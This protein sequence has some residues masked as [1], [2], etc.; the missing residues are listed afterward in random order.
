[1]DYRKIFMVTDRLP[2]RIPAS[3]LPM[4]VT[5]VSG[6]TGLNTFAFLRRRYGDQ[7]L[8]QRP[9]VTEKL[10]GPGILA[11]DLNDPI[12]I[13]SIIREHGI[14]SILSTGGS[15][16]LKGCELDHE[17][18]RRVNVSTVQA[19][20]DASLDS[21]TWLVHLSI[22]LVFGGDRG[23][24]HKEADVI[25]PATMYGKTM[26]MAEGVIQAGKPD[27]CIGRISL[28]MG[29]S[30]NQHA[31]AVDWIGSRFIKGRPATLYYD[32]FRTPTYVE[33]LAEVC[34]DL[35]A[36]D[37]SGLW[38]LGGPR[39]VSLNEIGQIVN[40][41][42]GYDPDLLR[43]SFRIEAGP[44]PP[45][46]GNV[47]MDSSAIASALGRQPFCPWPY[48]DELVP[49]GRDWHCDRSGFAGNPGLIRK[50]LFCRPDNF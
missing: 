46:A 7:V 11:S 50:L 6:V 44:M 23:G 13:R 37:F 49:N 33:C 32:E 28:P 3:R 8:G 19:L 9:V 34:E 26:A 15:C 39:I 45:R 25:D 17:M 18:A 12:E 43:G 36:G 5:G 35:V 41:V 22:D 14:R 38:H 40:R 42:G 16:N 1:M 29:G 24:L 48:H 21:G 27:A 2:L 4:L 30:F 10:V 47:T 20:V 31:G